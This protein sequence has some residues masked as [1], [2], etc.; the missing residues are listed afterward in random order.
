[1]TLFFFLIS[2]LMKSEQRGKPLRYPPFDRRPPLGDVIQTRVVYQ[3]PGETSPP[4]TPDQANSY[5]SYEP[6]LS[7]RLQESCHLSAVR[8]FTALVQTVV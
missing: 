2:H 1:M 3:I 7:W 6:K 5:P 4:V 8:L